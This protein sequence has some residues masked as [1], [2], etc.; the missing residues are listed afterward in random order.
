[1]YH[2]KPLNT[3]VYSAI[4][5][6]TAEAPNYEKET[7][8]TLTVQHWADITRMSSKLRSVDGME[9][10]WEIIK[11]VNYNSFITLST[12]ILKQHYIWQLTSSI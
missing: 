7:K 1:M 8:S 3:A 12:K 2:L 4:R 5:N 9:I 10:T 11:K 6:D